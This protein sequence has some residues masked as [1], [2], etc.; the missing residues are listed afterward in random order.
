M[1]TVSARKRGSV[2][3][4]V[5]DPLTSITKMH[6]KKHKVAQERCSVRKQNWRCQ[7]SLPTVGVQGPLCGQNGPSVI[8]FHSTFRGFDSGRGFKM[9]ETSS[10]NRCQPK[11]KCRALSAPL[12]MENQFLYNAS[13]LFPNRLACKSFYL[14]HIQ[15]KRQKS[16]TN[17]LETL[18]HKC[19][20]H[21]LKLLL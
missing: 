10:P 16:R 5:F 7:S 11:S 4:S 1:V 6:K 3:S 8:Q 17:R 15:C 19:W 14:F 12:L 20:R 18:F 21:S 13:Y 2:L 9:Q